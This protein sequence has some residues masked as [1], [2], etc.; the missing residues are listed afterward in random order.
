MSRIIIVLFISLVSLQAKAW[1]WAD[2][3]FTPD[4]QGQSYMEKGQF[5]KAKEIF[6]RQDWAAS[7]AYKAG[8]YQRAAELFEGMKVNKDITTKV[9]PWLVWANTS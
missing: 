8:E 4:Q 7:A 9:M 6:E 3:W 1:T 5:A 2:L